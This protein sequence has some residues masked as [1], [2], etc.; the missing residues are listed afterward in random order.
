[1]SDDEGRAKR[2]AAEDLEVFRRA[3]ALSLD[4]HELLSGGTRRPRRLERRHGGAQGSEGRDSRDT[5]DNYIPSI[6]V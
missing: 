3:Y 6:S 5:R 2:W 1:M 4:L